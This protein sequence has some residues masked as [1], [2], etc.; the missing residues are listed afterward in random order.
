MGPDEVGE[1]VNSELP[2]S[3]ARK[4]DSTGSAQRGKCRVSALS[5][6]SRRLLCSC[7]IGATSK[8]LAGQA[9]EIRDLTLRVPRQ[10]TPLLRAQPQERLSLPIRTEMENTC[11]SDLLREPSFHIFR[12]REDGQCGWG[13]L[14]Y[15]AP[16]QRPLAW[17]VSRLCHPGILVLKRVGVTS[18][19]PALQTG[20]PLSSLLLGIPWFST[21]F[22]TAKG[23]NVLKD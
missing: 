10:W 14:Q 21:F 20:L 23:N 8:S 13:S 16:S 11:T 5:P 9:L 22:L 2:L 6:F 4:K 15:P 17:S 1:A 7:W 12:G 3:S 18:P 19:F